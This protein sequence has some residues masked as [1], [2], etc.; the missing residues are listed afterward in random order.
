MEFCIFTGKPTGKPVVE[1][2]VFHKHGLQLKLLFKV[3]YLG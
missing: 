1:G 3:H 2:I